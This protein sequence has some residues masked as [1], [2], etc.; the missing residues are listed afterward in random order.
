MAGS[1]FKVQQVWAKYAY[2]S[3]GVQIVLPDDMSGVI[4]LANVNNPASIAKP[5]P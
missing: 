2:I 1:L 3:Y 5:S 4:G